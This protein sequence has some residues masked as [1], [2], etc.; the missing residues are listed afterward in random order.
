MHIRKATKRDLEFFSPARDDL[1]EARALGLNYKEH[2]D[3]L[4]PEQCVVLIDGTT[5]LALG[6][7]NG[8]QVWFLTSYMVRHLGL[9]AKLQFRAAIKEYRDTMLAQYP[10]LWNYIWTGN[11]DHYRFLKSIGAEFHEE[12]LTAERGQFQL[13][14]IN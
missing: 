7:N 14:T 6:G 5:I 3:S 1:L 4:D 9:K 12:F 13:F 2:I 10:V 11:T 8:D